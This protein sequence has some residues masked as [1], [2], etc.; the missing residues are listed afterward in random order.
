MNSP[1]SEEELRN[2]VQGPVDVEWR[3]ASY[4]S[5]ILCIND[6][7]KLI[8]YEMRR[9]CQEIL[10]GLLLGPFVASKSLETLSSLKVSH[11]YVISFSAN[12][13]TLNLTR[14]NFFLFCPASVSVMRKKHSLSDRAFL[15][16]SSI[17]CWMLKIMKNKI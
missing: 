17:W 6:R 2:V 14:K 7:V 13:E 8:R 5:H 15:N 9:E 12:R 3:Q 1:L 4:H 16:I 10:P 11:M